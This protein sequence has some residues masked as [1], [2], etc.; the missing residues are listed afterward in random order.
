MSGHSEDPVA[1]ESKRFFT[2]FNLSMALV[3]IT[4]IEVVI[5]YVKPIGGAAII[6]VLFLTSIVKFIGVIWWFMHLRWDKIVNTVLFL[7]GLVI[8]LGTFFAVIYMG[9]THPVIEKFEVTAF[10]QDWEAEK[11]YTKDEFVKVGE[12]FFQSNSDHTSSE[13]FDQNLN[14]WNQVDGIPHQFSWKITRA[15]TVEIHSEKPE[16]PFFLQFFPTN[17]EMVE[18]SQVSLLS[19]SATTEDFRIKVRSEAFWTEN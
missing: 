18:G 5:I 13:N 14:L 16:N 11:D 2:F 17:Q 3:A 6:G 7:I 4:G 1:E 12:N 15:D 19:Q 9:D 8:A 10:T